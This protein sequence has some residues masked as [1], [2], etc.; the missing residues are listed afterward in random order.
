MR[1]VTLLKQEVAKPKVP[2]ANMTSLMTCTFSQRRRWILD[3][4]KPVSQIVEEYP[5]LSKSLFVSCYDYMRIWNV[6]NLSVCLFVVLQV[7]H[8][9]DLILQEEGR[10]DAFELSWETYCCAIV[11]Y[12]VSKSKSKELKHALKRSLWMWALLLLVHGKCHMHTY[13]NSINIVCVPRFLF[14]RGR[15]HHRPEVSCLL[16]T[17]QDKEENRRFLH[18]SG[19]SLSWKCRYAVY[20]VYVYLSW[21]FKSFD[22]MTETIHTSVVASYPGFPQRTKGR[23][24]PGMLMHVTDIRVDV[25]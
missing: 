21:D 15:N 14:Y 24:K 23:G 19:H 20:V 1:N 6:I 7:A 13:C 2:A 22:A 5:Y 11:S 16:S 10:S 12:A 4:A 25:G 18:E 17:H 3:E 8:E 9:L